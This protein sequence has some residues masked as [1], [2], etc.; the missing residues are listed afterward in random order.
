MNMPNIYKFNKNNIIDINYL[1]NI[2][3]YLR[4]NTEI[5]IINM[6]IRSLENNKLI[7]SILKNNIYIDIKN[8]ILL[9]S[10]INIA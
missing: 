1:N 4:S 3:L 2:I 6:I 7:I 10:K 9:S 5:Y 8:S